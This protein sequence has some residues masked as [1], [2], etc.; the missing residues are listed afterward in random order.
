MVKSDPCYDWAVDWWSLGMMIHEMLFRDLPFPD[1][2]GSR[3]SED[4]Y[5]IIRECDVVFSKPR[6]GLNPSAAARLIIREVSIRP[7]ES[8]SLAYSCASCLPR[9]P[10]FD[11]VVNNHTGSVASWLMSGSADLTGQQLLLARQSPSLDRTYVSLDC[12]T[13]QGTHKS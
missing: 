9:N 5:R 2:R 6:K 12:R 3:A 11:L 8:V 4:I 13:N 1:L 7:I 10:K